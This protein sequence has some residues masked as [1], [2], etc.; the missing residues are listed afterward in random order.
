MHSN[1]VHCER[2]VLAVHLQSKRQCLMFGDS[3]TSFNECDQT[4]ESKDTQ[5]LQFV[6]ATV[7]TVLN[8]IL[9]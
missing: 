2:V 1:I 8:C 9:L 6:N 7:Y 3:P 5:L 4:N